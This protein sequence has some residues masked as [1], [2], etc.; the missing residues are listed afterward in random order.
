MYMQLTSN[1]FYMIN[2][3]CQT[4]IAKAINFL[5]SLLAMWILCIKFALILNVKQQMHEY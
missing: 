1:I 2:N 4:E 3:L 5:A